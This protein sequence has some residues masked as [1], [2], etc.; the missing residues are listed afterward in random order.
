MVSGKGLTGFQ[1]PTRTFRST[2]NTLGPGDY[3]IA[4]GTYSTPTPD[5]NS[6]DGS[7]DL[8]GRMTPPITT[9]FARAPR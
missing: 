8:V 9:Q 5:N 6:I 7:V 1:G 3:H 2:N 4:Q